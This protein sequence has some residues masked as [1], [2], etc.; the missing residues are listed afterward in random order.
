[1]IG[2]AGQCMKGKINSV[3]LGATGSGQGQVAGVLRTPRETLNLRKM[4]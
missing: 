4:M 1:M 2:R 3:E